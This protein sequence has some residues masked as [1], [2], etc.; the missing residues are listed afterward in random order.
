MVVK[1]EGK[2]HRQGVSKAG[3]NYD[4]NVVYFLAKQRGVD[5]LAAVSKI[6]D[7]A[8]IPY[9]NII[10]GQHYDIEIDLNGNIDGM[11]VAKA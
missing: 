3:K 1:I 2:E 7:T 11:H 8:L 9:D 5:G 10:V 4:F 6:V